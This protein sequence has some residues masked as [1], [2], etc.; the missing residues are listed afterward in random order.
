M[1]TAVMRL[2]G[3]ILFLADSRALKKWVNTGGEN[4]KEVFTTL[5]ANFVKRQDFYG[6]ARFIDAEGNEVVRIDYIN[7][8]IIHQDV[9]DLQNKAKR[10]YFSE[11][12][13]LEKDKVYISSFDLNIE[14]G[15]IEKPYNPVIR[16]ATPIFNEKNERV[17]IVILNY[18]GKRLLNL[19]ENSHNSVFSEQ[20]LINSNGYWLDGP[21]PERNWAFH[22][23]ERKDEIVQNYYPGIWQ[24]INEEKSHGQANLNENIVTYK[25][26]HLARKGNITP[27]NKLYLV[28]FIPSKKII[29]SRFNKF[30]GLM[31]S[32]IFVVILIF[33]VSILLT[34]KDHNRYLAEETLRSSE[35]RFRELMESAPDAIV[36]TDAKGIISIVNKQV[37]TKFGY[38]RQ[39]LIGQPIEVL[40]PRDLR[41]QHEAMRNT[42]MSSPST[43]EMGQGADLNALKKNGEEFPVEVSLS[44]LKNGKL[45]YVISIVRDIT[46]RK[47]IEEENT[48]ITERFRNLVVNLPICIFRCEDK[49]NLPIIEANPA[50]LKLFGLNAGDVNGHANLKELFAVAQEYDAFKENMYRLTETIFTKVSMKTLSGSVFF[51]SLVVVRKQDENKN[52]FIDGCRSHGI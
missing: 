32:F 1:K 46:Q 15:K 41:V 35:K 31:L 25:R 11:A 50:M 48:V 26:I 8:K 37:E 40:L 17:G 5:L 29:E 24:F 18:K 7:K 3:D 2:E 33:I 20:W 45:S 9:T 42:Y 30:F 14:Y 49:E 16:I 10:Y 23:P 44:P 6:Q 52:Y 27:E 34:Y 43:R 21:D 51:A 38:E 12:I 13:K 19:Y 39:E 4:E 22:F 36:I 47:K 28:T